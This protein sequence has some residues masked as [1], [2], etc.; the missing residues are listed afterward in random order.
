MNTQL[1]QIVAYHLFTFV[2]WWDAMYHH[3]HG[4]SVLHE[5]IFFDPRDK[6]A[7]TKILFF[8]QIE[9]QHTWHQLILLIFLKFDYR[10]SIIDHPLS[11]RWSTIHHQFSVIG[12]WLMMDHQLLSTDNRLLINHSWLLIIYRKH[13]Q[14][15]M[16]GI[17]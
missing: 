4:D 1:V 17:I 5:S 9:V 12:H 7:P 6:L 15:T 10:S 8:V 16:V 3:A 13:G 2:D 11:S 14:I